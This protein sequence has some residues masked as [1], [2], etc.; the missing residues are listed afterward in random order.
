MIRIL[1]AVFAGLVGLAFGSFLNVCLTR[2]PSGESIV[3]P[4]SMCRACRRTLA[5]WENIPVLS[6]LVLR[7]RCRTCGVWIGWRYPMVELAVGSLWATLAWQV[8]N[9]LLYSLPSGA[10]TSAALFSPSFLIQAAPVAGSKLVFTWL[11]VGLAALDSEHLWL[12]DIVTLPGILLGGILTLLRGSPLGQ[13][14]GNRAPLLIRS[15]D[16]A[17]D[18]VIAAGI[19]VLIRG[20]YWLIRRR[21]GVGLGDAKL[22][23]M[24]AAWLGLPGTFLAFAVG[25][26]LGAAAALAFLLTPASRLT[27]SPALTKLPLGTFLCIGAMIATLWGQEILGAYLRWARLE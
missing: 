19:I 8:A 22:M 21:E 3:G 15:L 2:L 18:L 7:G 27:R 10:S 23:A 17:F 4:R 20:V 24:L 9:P 1:G 11:L 14:A 6:W 26:L 16:L 25:V 5:W 12:P 13:A